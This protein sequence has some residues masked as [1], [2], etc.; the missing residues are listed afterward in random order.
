M[1]G[2]ALHLNNGQTLNDKLRDPKSIVFKWMEKK[3]GDADVVTE[4]FSRTLGRE[5]SGAERKKFESLL[6]DAAKTGP[7]ARREA[8]EDVVWAIL[9]SKEFLFNH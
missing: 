5:P 8:L 3:T 2:Q 7:D 4:L 9:T 1:S 6:A